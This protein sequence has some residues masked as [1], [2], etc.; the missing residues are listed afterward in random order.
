[1][2]GQYRTIRSASALS[3]LAL[4]AGIAAPALAQNAETEGNVGGDIIVTARKTGENILR[5]P[6]TVTALTSEALDAR[7]IVAMTDLA[8]STPGININNSSSG[9]AD[10]SFQQVILRGMAP[11]TTLATT[12]SMFIDG[13]AVSSP[14]QLNAVSDPERVEIIKGPQSAYFGRNTFAGA[15]NV[16]NKV[17]GNDWK[18]QMLGMVGT[19]DNWRLRGSV[20]GPIIEDL[21][22]FRVNGEKYSKGGSYTNYDGQ[23]LGDQSTTVGSIMFAITPSADVK[24]KLFGMMSEDKD[25]PSA[26]TRIYAYDA[27]TASGQTVVKGQSNCTLSG[28]TRGVLGAD[29]KPAGTAVQNNYFCGTIGSSVNPV[30]ANV[31]N[32]DFI[33]QFL[34][35]G[36]NRVVS[37]EDGVD[38]YGLRRKT[39]HVHGTMDWDIADGLTASVLAGYNKETWSTLIDLDGYDTTAYTGSTYGEGYFNYPYLIERKI[40]DFSVEGRLSYKRGPFRGVAGVSYLSADQYQGLG[41]G[42]GKLTS[43]NLS[44]GGLSRNKTTGMFF[45]LTYDV[46][47]T[48]SAS[49]EGR[50]QIDQLQAFAGASGLNNLSSAYIP[51][52]FYSAGTLLASSKYKNFTPR[53]I[54]NWQI[55]PD[56]MVYASWSKGVNPAQFNTSILSNVD[57]V[58]KASLEAGGQLAIEPEK[59]TNYEIGLK[60]RIGSTFRYAFATYYAQWT[61]QI[62]NVLIVAPDATQSTG[63][64]FV[65]AAANTGKVDLYGLEGDVSWRPTDFLT[66]EAA[67]AITGSDIKEFSSTAV[68]A[69]TGV[70]DFSGKE[71]KNTSKYSANVGVTVGT[72]IAGWDRGRWFVRGDWNFK[73]GQWTNEANI[74][75]TPDIHMFNA[76]AGISHGNISLEAFVTN[77]FNNKKPISVSD[78]YLF[79]PNFQYTSRYS[80]LQL[81]LPDLRTA[82]VQAKISF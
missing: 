65:N 33:R 42:S 8:A 76:R 16:V 4:A 62:N 58:Q 48:L 25:G 11:S 6:V 9:H 19:R 68:S 71:M 69:L 45:G 30:T 5:T 26:Q 28:D 40:E 35:I 55:N 21:I 79:T 61:N 22:A 29:G 38:G 32:T 23:R 46:T 70:Y 3:I 24:I 47:S 10:R 81:G 41:G 2:T 50:Y 80:A 39:Q 66:I 56:T 1:M 44:G 82:G 37:P 31:T 64:S 43:A 67:G 7:G 15:I 34:A 60:G 77:I 36:T 17:P 14:S 72:D 51:A 53:V 12:T 52:G 13:V 54:V 27:K 73:S 49:V 57:S 59:V 20:E 78:N 63:Y 74:A 18:G 75:R